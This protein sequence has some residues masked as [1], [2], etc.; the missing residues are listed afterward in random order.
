MGRYT[1]HHLGLTADG[2]RIIKQ[3]VDEAG[4]E[5]LDQPAQVYS[6]R[7]D[8]IRFRPGLGTSLFRRHKRLIGSSFEE[9]KRFPFKPNSG[10]AFAV[11]DG[12]DRQSW[13]GRETLAGFTGVRNT[14]ML[15]FQQESPHTYDGV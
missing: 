4:F 3:A 6:G 12:P 5:A 13:H 2:A 14:I 15:L 8:R 9:V 7:S 1:R 11:S 10:Y